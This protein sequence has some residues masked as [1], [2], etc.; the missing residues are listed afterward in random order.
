MILKKL[1]L[2]NFRNYKELNLNFPDNG[3]IFEG[4]N[5]SGKTNILES[6]HILSTG[7]SQRGINRKDMIRYESTLATL[8][9]T[10]YSQKTHIQTE[11]FFGFDREKKVV[12][13][14]NNQQLSQFSDW[15]GERPIVSFGS[16]DVQII[17]GQPANRRRF[18]DIL[19]SHLDREYLRALMEYKRVLAQ[20]N[21]LLTHG[22]DST[23]GEIY[24]ESMAESGS[25]IIIARRKI[26]ENLCPK[27]KTY[28]AEICGNSELAAVA[29]EPSF[30]CDF[31][32][33]KQCKEVFYTMLSERRKKDEEMGYSSIGPHRDDIAFFLNGKSAKTFGSQG[34]CRSLVLSLKLSSVECL[35]QTHDDTMVFL[36]DDAVSELDAERTSRVYPLLENKGQVFIASP[37]R[38]VFARGS[39]ARFSV[40]DGMAIAA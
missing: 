7:R 13:K 28:Y 25:T 33:K 17:S 5:G 10:F 9:G 40:G 34:Q 21:R 4:L 22:Y 26:I 2:L 11:A 8:N 29:Y 23:L 24:E 18:I 35:E 3:A 36:I 38:N 1:S 16:D 37:V 20:R 39:L 12:M 6:I 15:F 19:G 31:D 27:T 14:I 30:S 32:S